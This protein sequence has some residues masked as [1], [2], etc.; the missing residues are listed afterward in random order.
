MSVAARI[1]P[2]QTGVADGLRSR[3]RAIDPELPLSDL[4]PMEARL[5]D[6][7]A[8]PRLY[9]VLLARFAVLALFLAMLVGAGSLVKIDIP[10][11]VRLS[12]STTVTS[13]G[14]N[15]TGTS[16]AMLTVM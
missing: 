1:D 15:S 3:L 13:T 10:G 9:A 14:S 5:A 7:V 4:S 12:A 2:G 6:S 16:S 8:R 11:L